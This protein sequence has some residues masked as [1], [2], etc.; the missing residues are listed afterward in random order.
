M[1]IMNYWQIQT[2]SY[3]DTDII[4]NLCEVSVIME[5]KYILYTLWGTISNDQ[6]QTVHR[7]KST[8]H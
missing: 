7:N 1:N 6:T 2:S 8:I 5:T 4:Y 3:I